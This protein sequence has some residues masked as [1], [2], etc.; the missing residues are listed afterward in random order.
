MNTIVAIL[1]LSVMIKI[2]EPKLC[3]VSKVKLE[4]EKEMADG[5]KYLRTKINV[6]FFR[7]KIGSADDCSS[8]RPKNLAELTDK[9]EEWVY[10]KE[11][12][13]YAKKDEVSKLHL[14]ALLDTWNDNKDRIFDFEK[15]LFSGEIS[16]TNQTFKLD[17]KTIKPAS[18]VSSPDNEIYSNSDSYTTGKG[19]PAYQINYW[20]SSDEEKIPVFYYMNKADW[21]RYIC[22]KTA[23]I[24]GTYN[25]SCEAP[26]TIVL[27]FQKL[28]TERKIEFV[29]NKPKD[30]LN[31]VGFWP[32]D[33]REENNSPISVPFDTS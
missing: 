7:F 18:K 33:G 3:Y 27:V 26:L 16:W 31:V 25:S 12:S 8:Q 29:L 22:P 19:L 20:F 28:E 13:F 6:S 15:G 9:S 30:H 21:G 4:F 17:D 24:I 23:A 11:I 1:A 10:N 5:D 14:K 32:V 2:V